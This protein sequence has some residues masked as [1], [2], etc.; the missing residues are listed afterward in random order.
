DPLG[1]FY[2]GTS[3]VGDLDPA[4]LDVEL[5]LGSQGGLDNTGQPGGATNNFLLQGLEWGGI[6]NVAVANQQALS[7]DSPLSNV[8][9][10]S[11]NYTV[12]STSGTDY[13]QSFVT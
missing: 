11:L 9:G 8:N 1:Q 10:Q 12:T 7:F 3:I 4:Q 6:V 5:T 13:T 2:F